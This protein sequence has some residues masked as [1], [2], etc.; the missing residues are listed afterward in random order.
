MAGA[1]RTL[2]RFQLVGLPPAPRGIPQVEVTFD[3]DAN[4]ILNVSAKDLATGKEQ[5]IVITASSGLA[6]E[7][8]EKMVKEAEK[9][10]EEDKK[11]KETIEVAN[12]LDSLIYGIQKMINENKDKLNPDEAKKLE[13]SIEKARAV[14]QERDIDK[15]KASIE[16]L[17]KD[18]HH[19]A[20]E[21][22]KKASAA[23][24][25]ASDAEQTQSAQG[26]ESAKKEDVIDAEFEEK[27]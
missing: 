1:N 18:S 26:E 5:K 7:D 14:L 3:I 21:M 11:N 12:N 23:G 10:A 16:Q 17:N 2:G 9:H 4:G 6:K 13:E 20:E 24:K 8:V 15:M 19:L 25:A 27:K 22:Y